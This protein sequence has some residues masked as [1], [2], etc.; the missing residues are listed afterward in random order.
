M[1]PL[2]PAR[3]WQSGTLFI[4]TRLSSARWRTLIPARTSSTLPRRVKSVN[5]GTRTPSRETRASQ[6]RF[7]KPRDVSEQLH[8]TLPPWEVSPAS[9]L[10]S[11]YSA[12]VPQC[13]KLTFVK[14]RECFLPGG[15]STNRRRLEEISRSHQRDYDRYT[16][17]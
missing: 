8:Y 13:L 4:L 6:T 10:R 1:M 7:C 11:K 2:S 3:M 12:H 5:L 16:R 17:C 15:S 14:V 9:L